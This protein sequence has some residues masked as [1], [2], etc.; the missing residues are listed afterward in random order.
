M[1]GNILKDVVSAV[2]ITLKATLSIATTTR[3]GVYDL[4]IGPVKSISHTIREAAAEVHPEAVA[5]V[6]EFNKGMDNLF[7]EVPDRVK[8]ATKEVGEDM[9]ALDK[10]WTDI[11]KGRISKLKAVPTQEPK[12]QA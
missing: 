6:A 8:A 1:A 3:D 12:A 7:K 9:N 11:K 2:S 4:V 5:V 10:M